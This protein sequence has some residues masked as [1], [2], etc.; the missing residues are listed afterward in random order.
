[1]NTCPAIP[2]GDAA[3][4]AASLASIDCQLNSA[5]GVAYS[6]L[7]GHTGAFA[8]ALTALLGIYVAVL[9]LGLIGGRAK[10]SLS[11]ALPRVLALGLV[12]T[13]ATAWPAYQTVVTE[14]LSR[15]PD[16]VASALLGGGGSATQT[17]A[18][19]LDHLFGSYV[20]LAQTLQAQGKDASANLQMSAKLAWSGALLLV[21]STAGLLVMVRVVLAILLALGPVF[22]VFALFRATR[23]LFEGWL[24]TVVGFALAPLL[25]VL[26]G[27]GL[28]ALLAP[29]LDAAQADPIAAG[30]AVQPLAMLLVTVVMYA[31]TLL[32]LCWAAFNLTRGWRMPRA[33]TEPAPA[34]THAVA[35]PQAAPPP[36]TAFAQPDAAQALQDDAAQHR[37]IGIT[38]ALG[39]AP[40]TQW[41]RTAAAANGGDGLRGS[42]D[43]V[44][45]RRPQP[46]PRWSRTAARSDSRTGGRSP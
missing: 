34:S 13:F 7:F 46:A 12:L 20:E 17:F 2:S 29:L 37:A 23:G 14:L 19:R 21:L 45:H 4:L 22:I 8:L 9:A 39:R 6:R 10:L 25:L 32:A 35:Q 18:H 44:P 15:G 28:I 43:V 26:G 27:A 38:T 30:E 36:R 16:Q 3:S 42:A 33:E 31:L 1:M 5:V 24:K 11:S 40:G 41:T